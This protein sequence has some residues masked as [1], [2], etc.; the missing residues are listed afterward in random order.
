LV[1]LDFLFWYTTL[2]PGSDPQE[3]RIEPGKENLCMPSVIEAPLEM[4]EA[5]A[6]LR[7]PPKADQWLQTLMDRN[8]DGALTGTERE[9][10][11][12]LV[13]LSER[14][15]LVRAKALHVLGRKPL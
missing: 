10:L 4:V 9:E 15:A 1:D 5:V 12:V 3:G 14:L 7:L 8:N 6:E 11:E 2:V 13:E